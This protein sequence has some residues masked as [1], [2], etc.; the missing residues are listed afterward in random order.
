M[1]MG[2]ESAYPFN[3]QRRTGLLFRLYPTISD[4]RFAVCDLAIGRLVLINSK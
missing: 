3:V 4:L 2:A 1:Y